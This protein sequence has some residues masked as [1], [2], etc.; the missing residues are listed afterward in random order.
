MKTQQS[1]TRAAISG[2]LAHGARTLIITF[3]I[4][5]AAFVGNAAATP[6]ELDQNF[7]ADGITESDDNF[8]FIELARQADG[9]I[10]GVGSSGNP[11]AWAIARF[12][13]DG[14]LD[15]TFSSD[16]WTSL[17]FGIGN[18]RAT[19]IAI[20]PDGKI[21][22][23]GT[24][25]NP[26]W[27]DFAVVRFNPDGTLDTTF[28]GDGKVVTPLNAD[29]Q[30]NDDLSSLLI[31]PDGL[32]VATGR[33]DSGGRMAAVRYTSTGNLDTAFG[34]SGVTRVGWE[35]SGFSINS[36]NASALQSD[37]KILLTGSVSGLSKF[38]VCRLRSNGTLDTSFSQD[39]WVIWDVSNG[40]EEPYSI[41][42]EQGNK[43]V[44][45]GRAIS[46][47]NKD[48]YAIMRLTNT[49][50]FDPTFSSDGKIVIPIGSA[51]GIA[52]SHP[53][54]PRCLIRPDGKI[55]LAGM[56]PRPAPNGPYSWCL[57][58]LDS[59]GSLDTTFS[60]DGLSVPPPDSPVSGI[61]AIAPQPDGKLLAVLN[62][63]IA[64]FVADE[65]SDS[66]GV[67]D[68]TEA[69]LGTAILDPDSDDDGLSDGRE[70]TEYQCNPLDLDSDDD[71]L[72]D[73]AEVNTH[74]SNPTM[75]D[76]DSDGL[77]D[78]EEVVTHGTNPTRSDTDGD[79][80]ADLA[81]IQMHHTDPHDADMDD[82]GLSD[83]FEINTTGSSPIKKDTDD[84]GYLDKFEHESGFSPTNANSHPIAQMLAH[85]AI[86]LEV[87]TQI[88]KTYRLQVSDDMT[89]WTDTD[90]LI[91]GTGGSIRDLFE[92]TTTGPKKFWRVREELP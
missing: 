65:D 85:P 46:I 36:C 4:A 40:R 13:I 68:P 62:G 72:L 8:A 54:G 15:P 74:H 59:I 37:G 51:V 73:G 20:Q 44:V 2:S 12:T 64:R 82:D 28:S 45:S 17:D 32:I 6:G 38:G 88:G 34:N 35:S 87:V 23:G 90:T 14:N 83:G 67:D 63:R 89:T 47:D 22:V 43:I 1:P 19:A 33:T 69:F 29:S 76:T 57:L 66:D 55:L 92:R 11:S 26:T 50:D 9:K 21:L 71:G 30:E 61:V 3:G 48:D 80:L 91:A 18:D 78:Y 49:G 53:P 84:D 56:Y 42:L 81:E 60:G 75:T 31:Q 77:T 25:M 5:L 86:E 7:G 24:A 79:G 58:R 39:G 27:S 16:G 52:G 70:V 41:A 10:V